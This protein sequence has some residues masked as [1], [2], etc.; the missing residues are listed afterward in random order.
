V[1]NFIERRELIQ[2][3]PATAF[4]A[5]LEV[6]LP[7]TA[8]DEGLPLTW[9]WLYLLERPRQADLGLDGHPTTGTVPEPPAPG[10]RRMWAGGQLKRLGTL[11]CGEWATRRSAVVRTEEKNGRSG[12]FTV[13]TVEHQ[14]LQRDAV[15]IEERQ[16]IVYREA[17]GPGSTPV[18]QPE[19]ATALV[20][21][22]PRDW[23]IPV[24]PTLLFRFSALTYNAHRIHYDRDYARETEGYP[25][26]VTHG[27][28]QVMAMAEAVRRLHGAIEVG[29]TFAYRLVSPLFEDQSFI[30]GAE[31][32][33]NHLE[34]SVR[35][36]SGR[37]TA[38]GTVDRS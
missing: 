2:P 19:P 15:V 25:A 37:H 22:R 18:A 36:E 32:T 1:P 28:L 27:P 23:T 21:P 35:D 6:P 14:I 5:L 29:E 24:T 20:P 3:E 16:D 26:L 34:T 38:R 4:A 33:G 11:R 7:D 10:L 30:V 17:A 8:A 9:H 13:V 31:H 12:R